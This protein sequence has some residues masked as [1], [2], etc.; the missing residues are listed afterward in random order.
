MWRSGGCLDG[1]G[2]CR[3]LRLSLT[4][5]DVTH[6]QLVW[7][8]EK[9]LWAQGCGIVFRDS[10]RAHT[11]YGEQPDAIGWRQSISILIECKYSR[12][13]FFADRNKPFRLD[14]RQGL[15]DWRFFLC[16]K[17]LVEGHELPPGWGLL[18]VA[19]TR[20]EAGQGVPR[21]PGD[22]LQRPWAGNKRGEVQMMYAA[23]RRMHLR[24]H[25]DGIY[26]PLS[27]PRG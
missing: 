23:L 11:T 7:L 26:Q 9:W 22:W 20:V 25:L 24:G 5:D 4:P 19:G 16:P 12:A 1:A 2:V 6:N 10:F 8:A 14:P 13:D 27:A 21:R 17:G 15:G 18:Q 3:D